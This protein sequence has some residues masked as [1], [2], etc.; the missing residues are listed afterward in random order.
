LASAGGADCGTN[1]GG[2][3]ANYD[4]IKLIHHQVLHIPLI[5]IS[6][7]NISARAGDNYFE[8]L[9]DIDASAYYILC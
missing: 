7:S 8:L 1:T 2:T 3:T 5:I 6:D 4:N 9:D